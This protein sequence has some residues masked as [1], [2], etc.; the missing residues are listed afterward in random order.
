MSPQADHSNPTDVRL[1]IIASPQGESRWS[2]AKIIGEIAIKALTVLFVAVFV[3][4]FR[5]EI[6]D[7]LGKTSKVGA[8]G[9]TLEK[10]DFDKRLQAAN[11]QGPPS[12]KLP[13]DRNNPS[14]T[15]VPFRKLKLAG[16]NLKNLKILWVDDHPENNFHVRRI[17]SD[18]GV[19]ITIAVNNSEGLD[20]AK[21]QD[22][23]IVISDFN[24]DPPL[25][26]N[27]GELSLKLRELGYEVRFVFYTSSPDKVPAE[28]PKELATN[29][30]AALLSEIAE[31][32][33]D[34]TVS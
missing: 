2:H 14:W 33:I 16:P 12:E 8:F 7:F 1:N 3:I 27:G 21:R 4:V 26:E 9:F 25:K 34:R 19:Q 15:D 22:F 29:D 31:L 32:S 13:I 30:P 17:L 11:Q 10:N 18:L 20:A 5:A 24:R 28:V 23:D 6:S